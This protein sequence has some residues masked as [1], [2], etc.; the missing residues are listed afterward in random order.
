LAAHRVGLRAIVC[1]GETVAEKQAGSTE[2]VLATQLAAS[3]PES[4]SGENTLIAYE[5]VWAIGS[6]QTPNIEDIARIHRFILRTL[7]A[8]TSADCVLYGGSVKASNAAKILHTEGVG[9]VLVGGA[10]LKAE[11]FCGIIEVA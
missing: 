9:G 11:E 8:N 7:S 2:A 5:P 10:S 4:A 1:V 3:L 6:G